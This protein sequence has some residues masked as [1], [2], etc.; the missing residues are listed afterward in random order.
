[1]FATG[2][3]GIRAPTGSSFAIGAYNPIPLDWGDG[4]VRG[5]L[6]GS[7]SGVVCNTEDVGGI[8]R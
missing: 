7:V 4:E 5:D 3:D 6:A 1:L 8:V 2:A